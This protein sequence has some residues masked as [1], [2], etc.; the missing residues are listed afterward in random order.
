[1]SFNSQKTII[2]NNGTIYSFS[3]DGN[4]LIITINNEHS[5]LLKED[6]SLTDLQ[7]Q[8]NKIKR[9]AN[10]RPYL[11][12]YMTLT[13]IRGIIKDSYIEKYFG[14]PDRL[15]HRYWIK[16][17]PIISQWEFKNVLQII[18]DNQIPI[19]FTTYFWS[20]EFYLKDDEHMQTFF[21]A[22][23]DE[24]DELIKNQS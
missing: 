23:K 11:P 3:S 9:L 16:G 10:K 1:M 8:I 15:Y 17:S 12:E 22:L 7:D 20:S 18:R 6:G 19:R 5:Y 21:I 2:L 14:S 4:L 13:Q 24:I